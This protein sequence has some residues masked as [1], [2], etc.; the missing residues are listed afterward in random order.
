[1]KSF[2]SDTS[3]VKNIWGKS[4]TVLFIFAGAAGEFA[5]NKSVDWL[6]FTGKLPADPIGRLF[7]TVAYARQIIFSEEQQAHAA[8]DRM[9]GIHSAVEAARGA[10]IPDWA[11]RDVLYMLVHYSITAFELLERELSWPEKE[12]VCHVFCRVGQRMGIPGLPQDYRQWLAQRRLQLSENLQYTPYTLDL[13]KQYRK[14][15]GSFRYT[16]LVRAQGHLLPAEALRLLQQRRSK[17]FGRLM[18]IYRFFKDSRAKDWIRHAFLPGKYRAQ[19]RALDV[20]PK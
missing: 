18:G 6:Y 11:F 1:M 20:I 10:R 17:V 7:S 14:H 19:I 13:Y 2:V 9:R 16:I 4:D 8:I 3:I 5:L 15:L 12:E